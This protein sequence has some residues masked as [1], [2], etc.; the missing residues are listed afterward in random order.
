MMLDCLDAE[1]GRDVCFSCARSADEDNVMRSVHELASMQLAHRR[2]VDFAGGEV[3]AGDVLVGRKARCL[4]MIGDGPDLA[5]SHFGF[6]QLGQDRH[7][8]IEG[9]CSLLDQ[10][11]DRLCH[12]IH[13]QATKHDDDGGAS[14]RH[15]PAPII[16][17]AALRGR[18]T[19]GYSTSSARR[20]SSATSCAPTTFSG[21]LAARRRSA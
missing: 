4:H 19:P 2:L 8:C 7:G 20:N 21:S 1:S 16:I 18:A 15:P 3:V 13:L 5:L 11:R 6:Q 14:S 12:A 9:R 10:V 17:S